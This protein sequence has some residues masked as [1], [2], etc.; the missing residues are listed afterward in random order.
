MLELFIQ[1]GLPTLITVVG[2]FIA[3]WI[4]SDSKRRQAE[5]Q[6][7]VLAVLEAKAAAV[8][9]A[10]EMQ[11]RPTIK[12][13]T[14]DGKLSR[15]DGLMLAAEAL[16]ALLSAAA[17]EITLLKKAGMTQEQ[18]EKLGSVLIEK[19][20]YQDKPVRA[21]TAEELRALSTVP[22]MQPFSKFL[23]GGSSSE[24]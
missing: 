8:F 17:P 1:Y 24:K 3:S 22:S 14:K 7:S 2:G 10:V 15:E 11:L 13:T 6:K 20:V 19:A 16:K 23:T 21:P 5:G 9:A 18:I 4:N 12:A